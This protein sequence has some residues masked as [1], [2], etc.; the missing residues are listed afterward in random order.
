MSPNEMRVSIR[1]DMDVTQ[2]VLHADRFC[3][4]LDFDK[5]RGQMVAT[6]VSELSHNIVK[7]ASHGRIVL[8]PIVRGGVK[9]VEVIA[10]D[11]GP[12]IAD[13]QMALADHFS[14]SGTLGLGLPGVKRLMD[15]FEIESEPDRGTRI[16]IRKWR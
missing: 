5:S 8:R 12:G 10:E 7:Y 16:T 6:A 9:G 3:A 4:A 14:T 1:D 15:E 13:V 11:Q 2:A